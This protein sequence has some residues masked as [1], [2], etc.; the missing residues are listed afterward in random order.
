MPDITR[1]KTGA[2]FYSGTIEQILLRYMVAK[3]EVGRWYSRE[4]L[5][6]LIKDLN[7]GK[8][9]DESFKK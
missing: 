5:N 4:K 1:F 7:S 3:Y 2:Q 6:Q 9:F 8:S